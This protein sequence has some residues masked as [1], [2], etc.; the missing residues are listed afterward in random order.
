MNRARGIVTDLGSAASHMAAVAREFRVPTILNT[1][2]ATEVLTPGLVVTVD[3][4]N[5]LVYEG[6]VESLLLQEEYRHN[7]FE[8]TSLFILFEKILARIV[9]LNLV[10]PYDPEFSAKNCRTFHDLTRFVHQTATQEMFNLSAASAKNE[11]QALV[12]ESNFPVEIFLID[13]GGG[14]R[15][16]GR[17]RRIKPEQIHSWP[18]R[19]LWQGIET[20]KWP[21]PKPVDVKG[22]ASVVAQT[23]TTGGG[24]PEQVYSEKSF[25][26]LSRDY[27]NF[28]IRL[29]YHLSTI[30]VY[31]AEG[32]ENNYIKF[33]FKGGGATVERRDRRARLIGTI[34]ERL[35]FQ[36]RKKLDLLEA[37][38]T[39]QTREM[40]EKTLFALGKLTV[41]TKQLDMVMYN[42]AIVDW[43]IE[44]FFKEHLRDF[45]NES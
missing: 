43:S 8:F 38:L 6:V 2:K 23:A 25:A 30:E 15:E 34:L 24:D 29:G 13:L 19:A 7:P 44:E 4:D 22:F 41:Y 32:V 26:L 3:A 18:M 28:S 33:N 39:H 45:K 20:M 17:G 42:E 40:L 10:D 35:G 1:Q 5:R 37:S 9:P 11:K 21:G 27:L 16:E 12:L 31:G 36:V 14:I